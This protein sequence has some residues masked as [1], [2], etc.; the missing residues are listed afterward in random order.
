MARRRNYLYT[1]TC[2]VL[3]ESNETE[4]KCKKLLDT[5]G[6]AKK[7][8]L[9]TTLMYRYPEY[10]STGKISDELRSLIEKYHKP[11][12]KD[13]T[14][15]GIFFGWHFFDDLDDRASHDLL[16]VKLGGGAKDFIVYVLSTS[17][18]LFFG[19]TMSISAPAEKE[20][21]KTVTTSKVEAMDD[22][23]EIEDRVL[24][25]FDD[26]YVIIPANYEEGTKY[27]KSNDYV[28]TEGASK[29]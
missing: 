27:K 2:I 11:Y 28:S 18:P 17:H 20:Q 5:L 15:P 23:Y 6:K 3:D 1:S 25:Q 26:D 7:A 10:F 16:N 4:A 9:Q 29:K 13:E 21:P 8:F 22:D 14:N 24:D 12:D 19:N